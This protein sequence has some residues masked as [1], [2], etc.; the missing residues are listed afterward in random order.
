MA[1]CNS[2]ILKYTIYNNT[3]SQL[4]SI[5]YIHYFHEYK[6]LNRIM[7]QYVVPKPCLSFFMYSSVGYTCVS[8]EI[9]RRESLFHKFRKD[10]YCWS[11]LQCTISVQQN[12]GN[13]YRIT[14][15]IF[16]KAMFM[17]SIRMK[18]KYVDPLFE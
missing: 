14:F 16:S 6:Y 4:K 9:G 12:K 7:I 18:G 1:H 10:L 2:S 11:L 8:L 17:E 15:F 13:V 5:Q 3:E